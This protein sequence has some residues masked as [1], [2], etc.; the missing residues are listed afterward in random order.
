M[1][2]GWE[3]STLKEVCHFE[4]GDR[5]EN[6][7]G[8]KAFVP[9]GIP[10][11]NAG[12]LEGGRVDLTGMNYIPKEHFERLGSGKIRNGDLL[13]CLRGSLGKYALIDNL[14]VGAIAS[15]LVIVRPIRELLPEYLAFF[16]GSHLCVEQIAKYANGAAQPNLSARSL[17]SFS[18]PL[19]PLD[20]QKRIVGFLDEAFEGL[21]RVRANAEANL[22]DA[23]ELI[24]NEADRLI[25]GSDDEWITTTLDALC[26]RFEYGTSA[27]SKPSGRVPVLRMG[28]L[29]AGE[30][31]WGNLVY[32]DDD[33]D[34]QAL[35]LKPCDVLFNRTNSLEHVGKAAI[36]RGC[37][38]AIFAGYLI[39]LHYNADRIDPEF[40]NAFLNS[41]RTRAYGRTL[42]GKSVNQ[43]N[44]SAGKL[45]SY[46]ISLPPLSKQ[47]EIVMKL[48]ELKEGVTQLTDKYYE[49]LSSLDALRQSL[50]QK[51]F[52]GELT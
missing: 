51:A 2:A 25:F 32:T 37:R 45:K 4:N 31:D 8:R 9:S 19:A 44:I 3:V 28:N 52:S 26:E 42:S 41:R 23:R 35:M 17:A 7:P 33:T 15:S 13:F 20:E 5:G 46:P 40:L 18:I 21:A 39:R 36:Y 10:F 34:I 16:F 43:A 49:D 27:K 1:K 47:K 24:E 29:R 30:I 22:V 6:Y 11:I 38:E 50:L 12:H 48:A 14:E